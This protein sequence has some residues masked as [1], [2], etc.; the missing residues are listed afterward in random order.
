MIFGDRFGTSWRLPA[1]VVELHLLQLLPPLE[2]ELARPVVVAM[3]IPNHSC[4]HVRKLVGSVQLGKTVIDL[5]AC[6]LTQRPRRASS[7]H[8]VGDVVDRTC[9]RRSVDS[10]IYPLACPFLL[11]PVTLPVPFTTIMD[12][13]RYLSPLSNSGL[14]TPRVILPCTLSGPWGYIERPPSVFGYT[15]LTNSQTLQL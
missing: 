10:T 4:A 11:T 13:A 7:I 9:S 12:T 14:I 8:H 2:Y 5:L 15:I 1:Y 6:R 3:Y